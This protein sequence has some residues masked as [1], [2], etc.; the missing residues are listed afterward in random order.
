LVLLGAFAVLVG[1][2]YYVLM[3]HALRNCPYYCSECER[4]TATPVCE[5]CGYDQRGT[6]LLAGAHTGNVSSVSEDDDGR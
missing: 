5:H 6:A 3:G 1:I 2:I 4:F